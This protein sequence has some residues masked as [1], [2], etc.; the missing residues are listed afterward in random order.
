[1]ESVEFRK[2]F[3]EKQEE[4]VRFLTKVISI[5]EIPLSFIVTIA[6]LYYGKYPPLIYIARMLFFPIIILIINQRKGYARAS[7]YTIGLTIDFFFMHLELVGAISIW[8]NVWVGSILILVQV[9]TATTR[10]AVIKMLAVHYAIRIAFWS[11]TGF[12]FNIGAIEG[13]LYINGNIILC[14]ILIVVY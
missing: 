1:M 9:L 14:G 8:Y 6:Y 10:E 5:S 7:L 13:S 11:Y 3:L 12:L 4:Q 2:V